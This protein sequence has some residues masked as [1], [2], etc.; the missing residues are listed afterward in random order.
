M[1]N[2]LNVKFYCGMCFSLW[3]KNTLTDDKV[4]N[5]P[6][7]ITTQIGMHNNHRDVVQALLVTKNNIFTRW[8]GREE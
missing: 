6:Q 1:G 4:S 2:W 3:T 8:G 7:Q 5:N